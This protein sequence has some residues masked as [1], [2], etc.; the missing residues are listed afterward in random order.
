MWVEPWLGDFIRRDMRE[1]P[2]FS[3][4]CKSERG[5]LSDTGS[6]ITLILDFLA[7]RTARNKCFLT[8]LLCDHLS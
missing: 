3:T 5:P 1:M 4:I 7:S 8:Y 6:V 2:F